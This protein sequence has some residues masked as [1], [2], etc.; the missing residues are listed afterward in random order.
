MTRSSPILTALA[1]LATVGSVAAADEI[2]ISFL[3]PP[4]EYDR[5]YSGGDRLGRIA[6]FDFKTIGGTQ[7]Q[8]L[9]LGEYA[10]N[11]MIET[12]QDPDLGLA[13]D[14][15]SRS[16]FQKAAA[17]LGFSSDPGGRRTFQSAARSI[18]FVERKN[19]LLASEEFKLSAGQLVTEETAPRI[20]EMVGSNILA[21]GTITA[22]AVEVM[23]P[24]E[25]QDSKG[26]KTTARGCTRTVD[27]S[28]FVSLFDASLS[29]IR[30]SRTISQSTRDS[31]CQCDAARSPESLAREAIDLALATIARELLPH[32]RECEIALV[33]IEDDKR[34]KPSESALNELK[35]LVEDSPPNQNHLDPCGL[36]GPKSYFAGALK[37][38]A[39]LHEAQYMMGVIS[40]LQNDFP[41][42][43]S[44]YQNAAD[45]IDE[46]LYRAAVLRTTRRIE[47]WERLAG[48]GVTLEVPDCPDLEAGEA[49]RS[50][51]IDRDQAEVRHSADRNSDV[52][53][54][55]RKGIRLKMLGSSGDYYEVE[56]LEGEKGFLLKSDA[57]PVQ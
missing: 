37:E 1:L 54:R 2:K 30:Y 14:P 49:S 52:L 29:Q 39:Y 26:K 46:K 4:A 50:V 56:L 11:R 16:A 15:G 57:K 19:L 51:R 36:S 47:G 53:R 43:R 23:T 3:C 13:T 44:Y 48:L 7:F 27:I 21:H 45:M 33:K 12:M 22:T 38:D 41:T 31:N 5:V 42:A 20:G 24:C 40:E 8:N 32:Y 28:I 18:E 34:K 10:A 6:V 25:T 55:L 9:P 35:R 17:S